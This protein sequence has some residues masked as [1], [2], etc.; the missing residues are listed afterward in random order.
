MSGRLSGKRV[1]LTGGVA[2]IGLAILKAFVAEG[3]TVSVVDIDSTRGADVEKRFG[4]RV[5]FIKADI[6][7]E[8]EIE[9]AISR[10]VD[11]MGGLDTLCL[12]AGIQLS[13]KLEEFTTSN[14]DKVFAINVRANFIFARESV[15]HLRAAKKASIVMMSSLAGKRGAPGLLSYSSSK[16]AVIGLTTTL[17]LELARDGI[18][19]NAVCPGWIDTP[20]NQ[21]AIEYL[22]GRD[23]QESLVP[24][25]IPLGRQ[26]SPEEVAPLFV[27]LA[28]DEASYVTAQAIN[29]DGGIYN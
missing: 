24:I 13:G 29:V 18:R 6:S 10:S 21:P 4:E 14:W 9:A 1:L 2:N 12:N 28:S 8:D 23:K 11:W 17:A 20:F 27:Y 22:G 15:K 3:A 19:V 26:A 7:K 16:A 5:R 25:L